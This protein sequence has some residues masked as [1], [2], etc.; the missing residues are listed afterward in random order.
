VRVVRLFGALLA[1]EFTITLHYRWW[2]A[3]LQLSNL[4]VPVVSLLVWRG[5]IG[6]GARPP[7]SESFLTTYLVLVS[8][9]SMLTSSWTARYLA[10]SIRLGTVSVWLVRP[11]STHLMGLAN[12][13]AEKVVKGGLML[14]PVAL[15]GLVFRHQLG[16]PGEVRRWVLF[17]ASVGLAGGI[18]FCLDVVVGSL[19]F[20]LG[21][22][23][24]VDRLRDL[25]GRTLSGALIPLALFPSSLAGFLHVEPFRYVVS[26]PLEVL[27]GDTDL[28]TGFAWQ[29][30][31]FGGFASAAVV[32][33]RV[34]LRGYQGA[35][36]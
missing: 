13:V 10:D 28:R 23:A 34:G 2:L 4:V 32:I 12:N 36:A 25:L 16:L 30:A 26:F 11:C 15:L 6:L 1:R 27:L 5:A 20:W 19:A 24:A 33:W 14:P 18:T 8:L 9:V 29:A 3:T 22:I 31:W 21:D 7:V 35:G 17:A